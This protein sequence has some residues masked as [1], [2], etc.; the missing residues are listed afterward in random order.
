MCPTT[1]GMRRFQIRIE[2][3]QKDL[4][5]LRIEIKITIYGDM[6]EIDKSALTCLIMSYV[7]NSVQHCVR[8]VCEAHILGS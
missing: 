8:G 1:F 3:M 4:Q 2:L 7:C 6:A 5:E